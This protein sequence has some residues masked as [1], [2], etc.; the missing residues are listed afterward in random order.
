MILCVIMNSINFFLSKTVLIYIYVITRNTKTI[1]K[2][3][4]LKYGQRAVKPHIREH[5]VERKK[6]F[7]EF[8]MAELVEF[9]DKNGEQVNEALVFCSQIEDFVEFL[10]ALRGENFTDLAQKIG[11]DSGKGFLKVTLTLYN[12]EEVIP[13]N[14]NNQRVKRSG[15]IGSNT[16]Y[17]DLGSKKVIILAAMSGVPETYN[18]C[19]V[20]FD[21]LQLSTLLFKF[22]GDLKIFNIIGGLMSC[23]SSHP[24]CYCETS[25]SKKEGWGELGQ[26]RT[27]KNVKENCADWETDGA[28]WKKAKKFKNCVAEPRLGEDSSEEELIL[29][30]CPPPS[31]HLKLGLNHILDALSKVWPELTD[32]LSSLNVVHEPYHGFCLEGNE[33]SKVLKKLT[34][35]EQRLPDE[36][37]PFLTCM[38]DFDK[39]VQS[40]FGFTLADDYKSS[41]SLLTSSFSALHE[42]FNVS[43]SVKL[44]IIMNHVAQFIDLTGNPLGQYS[45][46]ETETCHSTFDVFWS[47]YK[48]K[49]TKSE[50]YPVQLLKA[51]LDYNSAHI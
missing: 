10:S 33:V 43:E 12:E 26:L 42:K 15:G 22:A 51:I 36:L 32:W 30:K 7:E 13:L 18:N 24:C 50:K 38:E 3:L 16:S 28:I 19:K 39:V 46:Q 37:E 35:L 31:L 1:L 23:S 14:N 21:K 8:Y 17:R 34:T 20:I 47:R 40:C 29:L 44:H 2:N 6:M 11:V 45:E 25:K 41:I 48:I 9:E 5:L 4:R 27:K 49:N